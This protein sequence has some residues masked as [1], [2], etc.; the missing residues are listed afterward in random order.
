M[1]YDALYG[2]VDVPA[3]YD[4][5]MW[6][7]EVQ[8]LR[9]VFLSNVPS[10]D[11]PGIAQVTRFEHSVGTWALAKAHVEHNRS[12]PEDA[13]VLQTAAMLHDI[14]MPGLGHLMEEGFKLGGHSFDHESHLDA[15]FRG[16]IDAGGTAFQ[17]FAG[18]SAQFRE[19]LEKAK[20]PASVATHVLECVRGEGPLGHLVSGTV[21]FDNLDNVTRMAYHMGLETDRLLPMEIAKAMSVVDGQLALPEQ[22]LPLIAKWQALRTRVYQKLMFAPRDFAAKTMLVRMLANL[23]QLNGTGSIAQEDWCLTYEEFTTKLRRNK[24][25]RMHSIFERLYAG[26]LFDVVGLYWVG[27]P[28]PGLAAIA[29]LDDKVKEVTGVECWAY[30]IP[31][32]RHRS[33]KV[34]VP[35]R[36]ESVQVGRNPTGWL[37]GAC[38]PKV[39]RNRSSAA[40]ALHQ[41]LTATFETDVVLH[42]ESSQ[43]NGEGHES[44]ETLFA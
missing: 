22:Y 41:M 43:Q 18:R 37:V 11:M 24:T 38:S 23:V 33:V 3:P 21:D 28:F 44:P 30:G 8:R 7:P 1:M 17:I 34:F 9:H 39:I 10:F 29:R 14:A 2:R 32:K 25:S 42:D 26:Q 13:I 6:A 4:Q 27:G 5:L 35:E 40:V 19:I 16:E 36:G 15:I 20:V 31:D 12:H